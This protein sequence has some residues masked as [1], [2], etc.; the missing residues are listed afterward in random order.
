MPGEGH[1]A[2]PRLEQL[3][4]HRFTLDDVSKAYETFGNAA[5]AHALKVLVS[6]A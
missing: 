5:R 3:I 1:L 4:T 6:A 2:A